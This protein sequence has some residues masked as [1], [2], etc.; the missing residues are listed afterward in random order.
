MGGGYD[1]TVSPF[2]LEL[3]KFKAMAGG[4]DRDGNILKAPWLL[5]RARIVDGL[6]QRYS[7]LPSELFK[8]DMDTM[9]LMHTIL[10]YAGDH[11]TGDNQQ[12]I[13]S[14]AHELA[15]ISKSL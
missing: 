8:E 14:T 5:Q 11:E 3:E 13:K 9:F 1:T 15:N 4:V 7:C 6:C 10:Y 12:P 2:R